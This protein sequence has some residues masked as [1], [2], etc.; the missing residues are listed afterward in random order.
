MIYDGLAEEETGGL[1]WQ[2]RQSAA[3][4]AEADDGKGKKS[5]E[6]GGKKNAGTS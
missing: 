3:Q 1:N 4:R 5:Q 2:V 6:V